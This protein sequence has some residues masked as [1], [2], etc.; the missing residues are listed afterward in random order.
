MKVFH[1]GLI[2]VGVPFLLEMALIV[3]LAMMLQQSD[4]DQAKESQYRRFAAYNAHMLAC[5]A[6]LPFFVMASIQYQ[7]DYFHEQYLKSRERLLFNRGKVIEMIKQSPDLADMSMNADVALLKMVEITDEFARVRKG[8]IVDLVEMMPKAEAAFDSNKGLALERIGNL[9][10]SG[11]EKTRLMQKKQEKLRALF[12]LVLSIGLIGNA[13]AAACLA[14]FYGKGIMARLRIISSNTQALKDGR[15]MATPISGGDE[16]TQLDRA[17]HEMDKRLQLANSRQRELFNNATDVICVLDADS[18][19]SR[20][21]QASER[22]WGR[23]PAQLVGQPIRDYI[24]INDFPKFEQSLIAARETREPIVAEAKLAGGEKPIELSWSIFWADGDQHY[25]CV[26]HDVTEQNRSEFMKKKFLSMITQDLLRPLDTMSRSLMLL[27]TERSESLSAQA[28][29]KLKI[30]EKNLHRLLGLVNDLLQVTQLHSAEIEIR[31][32]ECDVLDMLQQAG[33]E[34]EALADKKQI[35]I[36]VEA[37]SLKCYLDSNRILQVLVNLLSNAIKFSPDGATVTLSAEPSGE[38]LFVHVKDQGRGVP[39]SHLETIFEKFSQVEAADGKRKSGTGLGLPI[40]KQI[41]EDHG[42]IIGVTSEKDKGSDFWFRVPIAAEDSKVAL[43]AAAAAA[44]T[45]AARSPETTF[46]TNLNIHENPH[47][48]DRTNAHNTGM[49]ELD[50]KSLILASS[51]ISHPGS[52]VSSKKMPFVQLKQRGAGKLKLS[53]KGL[54]LIGVPLIFELVLVGSLSALVYSADR[55]REQELVQRNIALQASN[56]IKSYFALSTLLMS[57]YMPNKRALMEATH[58]QIILISNDLRKLVKKDPEGRS[59]MAAIDKQSDKVST[60]ILWAAGQPERK[61][62]KRDLSKEGLEAMQREGEKKNKEIEKALP[63]QFSKKTHGSPKEKLVPTV[64]GISRKLQKLV[65]SAEKKEFL[66]PERRQAIRTKQSE[67]L[68]FGLLVNIAGCVFLALYFSRDLTGRLQILADNTFRLS[69]DRPLNDALQG[70]DEI[71]E[72]DGMFHSTAIA[73]KEAQQKDNAVFDNAQDIICSI[74]PD[75]TFLKL[76][77]AALRILNYDPSSLIGKSIEQI[78]HP[79]DIEKVK[80]AFQNSHA[81]QHDQHEFESR[82]ITNEG[83]NSFKYLSWSFSRSSESGEIY[84]VMHDISK[85]K[86]LELL[87]Q[88]FLAMVSHDLRTP[89]TSIFVVAKLATVGAFGPIEEENQVLLK[90]VTSS[91]DQL[92]ELIND[93]LD[94][95][96]L[97]AGKMQLITAPIVAGEFLVS[98]VT[99][100]STA[101]ETSAKYAERLDLRLSEDIM[102]TRINA[103]RDRLLQAFTNVLSYSVSVTPAGQKVEIHTERGLSKED[104]GLITLRIING[105]PPTN[106]FDANKLFDRFAGEL[107]ANGLD[108]G[109]PESEDMANSV[110]QN[111]KAFTKP[112]RALAL[113]IAKRIIEEHNG[114]IGFETQTNNTIRITIKTLSVVPVKSDLDVAQI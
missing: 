108:T 106:Q 49:K 75:L 3:S 22:N 84:C 58:D 77:S 74:S 88:D 110:D 47:S 78:V 35:K 99:S 51:S 52:Q 94:I 102:S 25:Y 64:V 11:E 109:D 97:E 62:R 91:G 18:N 1:R 42:G 20:V 93:L 63:E 71:A 79:G 48:I 53:A 24:D 4:I 43:T 13:I 46:F 80:A 98:L 70:S 32:G 34:V 67:V 23:D 33:Q 6:E 9:V 5:C 73:L 50:S 38:D 68:L 101:P 16:I 87:K 37:T 44:T 72:L 96:K 45:G 60:Y 21:N 86:E 39:A 14:A 19:F 111:P 8:R 90:E 12:S 83:G 103:D 113:P 10:R 17:F 61:N 89:L 27:I 114:S 26:V 85:R 100:L 81:K 69:S 7:S 28:S 65:E 76:N 104:D 55:E 2:I 30:A 40:C 112:Q 56:I 107:P 41:I 59:I 54:L 36:A 66:I 15:P 29:E 92:I 95:E 57:D 82:V 105:A 31:K